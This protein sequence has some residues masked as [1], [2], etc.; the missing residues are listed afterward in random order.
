MTKY[1]KIP[2]GS[3]EYVILA[4]IKAEQKGLTPSVKLDNFYGG[5][6]RLTAVI[7]A[8][9]LLTDKEDTLFGKSKTENGCTCTSCVYKDNT[10][11]YEGDCIIPDSQAKEYFKFPKRALLRSKIA[12]K[13]VGLYCKY[14]KQITNDF[15]I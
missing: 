13:E 15:A 6:S 9:L 4:A 1:G 8:N 7:V 5:Y 10:K 11:I 12:G 14:S 3:P 2:Y